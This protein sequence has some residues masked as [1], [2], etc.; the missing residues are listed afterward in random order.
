MNTREEELKAAQNVYNTTLAEYESYIDEYNNKPYAIGEIR[1]KLIDIKNQNKLSMHNPYLTVEQIEQMTNELNTTKQKLQAKQTKIDGYANSIK[2]NIDLFT[3]GIQSD[4]SQ[5]EKLETFNSYNTINKKYN[6][7]KTLSDNLFTKGNNTSLQELVDVYY[8][9]SKLFYSYSLNNYHYM[10]ILEQEINK[11]EANPDY[12]SDKYDNLQS[13][14]N[15]KNNVD[16]IKQLITTEMG[17]IE[18]WR[19]EPF[20]QSDPGFK[21]WYEE[22]FVKLLSSFN[23]DVTNS[24]N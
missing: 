3:K 18:T 1:D 24:T 5:I 11:L 8:K 17:A 22:Q 20:N 4:L 14:K 6:E 10:F 15:L 2:E 23:S 7:V 16:K 19:T 21:W 9:S 13:K 12:T